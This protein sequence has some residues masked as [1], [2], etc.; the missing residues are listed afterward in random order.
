MDD[1]PPLPVDCPLAAWEADE[2]ET[3]VGVG[4]AP[5]TLSACFLCFDLNLLG[6]MDASESHSSP[7]T[8][9]GLRRCAKTGSQN[10]EWCDC[11]CIQWTQR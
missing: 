8:M 4:A 7:D 5:S 1:T 3:A 11:V 6:M 2:E 10:V 9:D